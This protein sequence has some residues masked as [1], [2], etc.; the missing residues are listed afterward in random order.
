MA[1]P[2]PESDHRF[3]EPGACVGARH[4]HLRANVQVESQQPFEKVLVLVYPAR[5]EGGGTTISVGL[6]GAWMLTAVFPKPGKH[7]QNLP[8]PQSSAKLAAI[9]RVVCRQRY[10]GSESSDF[11]DTISSRIFV[12]HSYREGVLR[13]RKLSHGENVVRMRNRGCY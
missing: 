7:R 3:N 10:P 12:A 1:L 13:Y 6:Y 9:Q 11:L 8:K 2:G 4:G 5:D